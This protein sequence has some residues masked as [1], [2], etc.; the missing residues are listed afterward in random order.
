MIAGAFEWPSTG[1]ATATFALGVFVGSL[2]AWPAVPAGQISLPT[3][4]TAYGTTAVALV[5]GSLAIVC[6]AVGTFA[7]YRLFQLVEQ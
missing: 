4:P 5:V 7:L 1:R 2:L 3:E 6:F